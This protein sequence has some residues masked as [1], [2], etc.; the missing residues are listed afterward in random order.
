MIRSCGLLTMI[1]IGAYAFSDKVRLQ[2]VQTLTFTRDA[3]T[4]GRRSR[5]L[6]QIECESGCYDYTPDI[7]QCY[8]RGSD[9]FDV[10]WKCDAEM[11]NGLSF[12]KVEVGCEGYVRIAFTRPQNIFLYI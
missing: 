5:P 10:N 9:G 8:N 4:T 11:P 2:D 7:V 3:Y 12:S 1:I 6:P